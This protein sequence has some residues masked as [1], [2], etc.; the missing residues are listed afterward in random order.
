MELNCLEE[1]VH[2]EMKGPGNLLGYRVLHRKVPE[3]HELNVP[4]NLVYA[5]M[6]EVDLSGLEAR[7]GKR[8]FSFN[9]S[10]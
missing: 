5:I 4:R 6:N 1:A 10:R 2:E 7:G 3:I 9:R 8:S